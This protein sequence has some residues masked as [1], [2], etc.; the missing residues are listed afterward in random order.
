M[1]Y[2]SVRRGPL[3]LLCSSSGKDVL[4]IRET[5]S[6]PAQSVY[7]AGS[8]RL[9]PEYVWTHA[10]WIPPVNFVQRLLFN[11]S[12]HVFYTAGSSPAAIRQQ[13]C[14]WRKPLSSLP[15]P[16]HRSCPG[17]APFLLSAWA[18]AGDLVQ[19]AGPRH[20][21]SG[22]LK[23][24]FNSFFPGNSAL[25]SGPTKASREQG[26]WGG[27]EW[28]GHTHNESKPNLLAVERSQRVWRRD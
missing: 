21:W 22:P 1:P 2:V 11:S 20:S 25:C 7:L 24:F 4:S 27:K 19:G 14:C 17:P 18:F 13:P 12:R 5:T 6:A 10:A 16:D 15:A 3:G 26:V 9:A 8:H 28:L 23:S